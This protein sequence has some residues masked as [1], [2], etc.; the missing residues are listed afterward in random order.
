MSEIFRFPN[1]HDVKVYRKSDIIQC[2]EENIIDKEVAL[3]VVKQC[4]ISAMNVLLNGGWA[5]IPYFGNIRI[6]EHKKLL[7]S[8]EM[9]G[10]VEDAKE[11]LSHENYVLFREQLRIDATIK[12]KKNR[13]Y[14]Y[15]LAKYCSNNS[16]L[17]KRFIKEKGVNGAKVIIYTLC[18]SKPIDSDE[19]V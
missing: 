12:A 4:E 16:K 5:G 13:Y 15:I 3:E 9:Q 10:I 14:N 1:G 19:Q 6:P 17:Y 7:N 18:N 11:T 2:I 8:E